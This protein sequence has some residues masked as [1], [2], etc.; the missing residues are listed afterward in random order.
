MCFEDRLWYQFV[1]EGSV[2]R[3]GLCFFVVKIWGL[4]LEGRLVVPAEKIRCFWGWVGAGGLGFV[5]WVGGGFGVG[6]GEF[7]SILSTRSE[8][9][10]LEFEGIRGGLVL[11]SKSRWAEWLVAGEV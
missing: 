5:A 9:F 4:G 1:V 11:V 8:I 7:E 6:A 3:R 2:L 10:L